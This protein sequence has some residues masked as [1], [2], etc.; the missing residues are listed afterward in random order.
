M[1]EAVLDGMGTAATDVD[2]IVELITSDRFDHTEWLARSAEQAHLRALPA[3]LVVE[4]WRC[5]DGT[6]MPLSHWSIDTSGQAVLRHASKQE[7]AERVICNAV[8][9]RLTDVGADSSKVESAARRHSVSRA[10]AGSVVGPL[11]SMG[12]CQ[13]QQQ[14]LATVSGV[15]VC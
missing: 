1:I 4:E 5:S 8:C 9:L 15:D 10:V 14:L 7:I 12:V 11:Y 3:S 2:M 6:V 13:L